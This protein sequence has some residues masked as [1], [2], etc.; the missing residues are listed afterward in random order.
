MTVEVGM[1]V[2]VDENRFLSV[3]CEPEERVVF[4]RQETKYHLLRDAAA[5]LWDEIGK[6][7][8]F[9]LASTS[10]E[11]QDP[12]AK[13]A[14]AGLISIE[15]DRSAPQGITRRVWLTRTS[16]A[17]AAAVVLPLVATIVTPRLA[18][19]QVGGPSLEDRLMESPR[20]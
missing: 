6:G 9:E 17:S 12:V 13:L 1:R 2:R 4:D 10:S 5:R 7:G 19:G 14:E 11:E 18:L 16:K 8:S 3:A 15:P 20:P